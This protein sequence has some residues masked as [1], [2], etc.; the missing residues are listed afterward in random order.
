MHHVIQCLE[1]V[2]INPQGDAY[3]LERHIF[4]RLCYS[5]WSHAVGGDNPLLVGKHCALLYDKTT[6]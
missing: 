4:K 3:L 1:V 2:R 6:V 5:I